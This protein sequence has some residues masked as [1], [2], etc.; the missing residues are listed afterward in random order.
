M[1]V[2]TMSYTR[3]MDRCHWRI[4]LLFERLAQHLRIKRYLDASENAGER[5]IWSIVAT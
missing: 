2:G 1:N 4:A 3:V 5:Q